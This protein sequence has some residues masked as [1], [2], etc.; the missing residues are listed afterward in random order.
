MR[1][2]SF[3]ASAILLLPARKGREAAAEVPITQ[4]LLG[5]SHQRKADHTILLIQEHSGSSH[6]VDIRETYL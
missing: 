1:W 3:L 5:N 6:T 4:L 2:R